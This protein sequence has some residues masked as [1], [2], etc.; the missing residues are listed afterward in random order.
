MGTRQ[1]LKKS[2]IGFEVELF[3]INRNGGMINGADIRS[4]EHTSEL[5]SRSDLLFRLLLEKNKCS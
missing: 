2:L 4:E 1:P 3:T 5:Q